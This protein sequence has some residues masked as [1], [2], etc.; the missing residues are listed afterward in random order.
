M[1]LTS[2]PTATPA[3]A[4]PPP[5]STTSWPHP[6]GCCT[7]ACS[8]PPHGPPYS[9]TPPPSNDLPR[10]RLWVMPRAK[11]PVVARV[12]IGPS[13]TILLGYS[14]NRPL[15]RRPDRP[16]DRDGRVNPEPAR[17]WSRPPR[18]RCAV[19]PGGLAGA[20]DEVREAGLTRLVRSLPLGVDEHRLI[21][22][23]SSSQE[24]LRIHLHRIW[25]IRSSS[26]P[27]P[28]RSAKTRA[29]RTAS[30][31]GKGWHHGHLRRFPRR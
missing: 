13:S 6:R 3:P 27:G 30:R 4:D 7:R 25:R 17:R 31:A 14:P 21:G 9:A 22:V 18:A 2:P 11:P 10:S 28:L 1:R 8:P 12:A 19:R 15:P 26:A 5:P 23:T 16:M 24:L 29:L 20:V